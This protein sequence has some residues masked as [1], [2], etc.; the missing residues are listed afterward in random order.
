MRFVTIAAAIVFAGLAIIGV[1]AIGYAAAG[2]AIV[3]SA[4]FLAARA[5]E[6]V[7]H[8]ARPVAVSERAADPLRAVVA[9]LPDPVI[10]LDRDGRV[11]AL[12]DGA[13]SLGAGAAPGRSG[14]ARAAD[15]GADRGDRPRLRTRRR[16]AR[17][18]FRARA[19]RALVRD[20]RDSGQARGE[21]GPAR[22]GADDLSRSHAAAARRGDAR[23]LRR[24]CEPRAAHAARRALRLHRD[25]AGPGARGRQGARALP[26]HHAGAGAAHGAA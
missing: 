7:S 10:A 19:D 1:L 8:A 26:R 24:Q 6:E 22:S 15:A 14:F 21:A 17:R 13:R 16:A 23:R 5:G 20:H 4:A 12:N 25:P 9:G 2:F 3:A 18:I 11:L